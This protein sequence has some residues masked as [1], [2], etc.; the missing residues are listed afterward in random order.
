M[1]PYQRRAI[2]LFQVM[3]DKFYLYKAPQ[4]ALLEITSPTDLESIVSTIDDVAK[5]LQDLETEP[6]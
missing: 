5:S 3:G 2:S 1:A 4:R 6:V